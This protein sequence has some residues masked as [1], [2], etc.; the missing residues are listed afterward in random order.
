[1]KHLADFN[2]V[3]WTQGDA[4][5]RSKKI[6]GENQQ[7]RMV[8]FSYGFTEH[9]WCRSSHAGYVLSGAF[10]VDYSGKTERYSAGDAFIIRAGET[11]KHKVV[12]GEGEKVTLLL[13][14][15]V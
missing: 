11:D 9:D 7:L 3:P 2:S 4:G 13:F 6:A 12:M 15:I 8:E 1:M 5:V 14:E 10:T